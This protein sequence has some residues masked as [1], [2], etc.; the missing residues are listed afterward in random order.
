MHQQ[1]GGERRV[2]AHLC[3]CIVVVGGAPIDLQ[4]LVGWWPLNGNA[5]D[6]SG[7]NNNGQTNGDVT[8]TNSWENGYTT[9]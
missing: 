3:A 8:F 1:P 9:P 5:H 2:R 7:N 4:N 6:Y